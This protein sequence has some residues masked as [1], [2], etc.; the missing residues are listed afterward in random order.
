MRERKGRGD[1]R[2]LVL[3][4]QVVGRKT[5]CRETGLVPCSGSGRG[6][7]SLGLAEFK[8]LVGHLGRDVSRKLAMW[9]WI[10][11]DVGEGKAESGRGGGHLVWV[12][13]EEETGGAARKVGRPR[14]TTARVILKGEFFL[15]H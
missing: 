4:A 15:F 7:F 1:D 6:D 3:G 10:W 14:E 12:G 13:D 11:G 8:G 2:A 9:V 5:G